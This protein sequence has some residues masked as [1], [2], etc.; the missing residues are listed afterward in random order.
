MI[1]YIYFVKCPDCADKHFDF[2]DEAKGFALG[3]LSKKPIITQ[4]EV[5]RNDFGECTDSNDLGMIWSWED[6][7]KE[8]CPDAEKAGSHILTKADLENVPE[9]DPEFDAL[10]N[11]V[12]TEDD[13]FRFINNDELTEASDT[14]IIKQ[15][16]WCMRNLADFYE[17]FMKDSNSAETKK[18]G[19]VAAKK[20]KARFSL[21]GAAFDDVMLKGYALWKNLRSTTEGFSMKLNKDTEADFDEINKLCKEIGIETVSDLDYFAKNELERD[22]TLLDKL[23][24][25]RA[26]LGPDFEIEESRKPVPEGMTIEQLVEEMEENEDE[27]ECTWCNELFPKD[28]CRYEVDLGYLCSR[29]EAAIK[30]RGETLT[31]RE[32]NYWDFLDEEIEEHEEPNSKTRYWMCWYDGNDAAV[33]EAAT[34]EEAA[35]T[36]MDDYHDEY[37]FDKWNHDWSV[38]EIS[39]EEYDE[40]ENSHS[41][42]ARLN[43]PEHV[44]EEHHAIE[45]DQELKGTDNAMVDCEV[46]DVIAHSEDEKPVDCKGK[47]KPL[48]KPLT[49]E[50]ETLEVS[51][52]SKIRL[53]N[54]PECGAENAF[55]YET[56]VCNSC[57]FII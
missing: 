22:G 21:S 37:V 9:C 15:A 34:E 44:N 33:V 36:F 1:Q 7:C 43:L 17:A 26:E 31:F 12:D 49:E 4:V 52:A 54:C 46:A 53:A 41:L 5:D 57:G 32:N 13:D 50:N 23:R 11:S 42:F 8:C 40:W 18:L 25:Y 29:C 27:V 20:L 3:C 6:E 39:K 47:K 30:S 45:S 56:G 2:F 16:A 19:R 48:E 51:P 28:Q 24:S 35:W 38:E 14:D 55:D 10:D